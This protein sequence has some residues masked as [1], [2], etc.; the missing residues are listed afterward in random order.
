MSY[1]PDT[2]TI[3]VCN[4]STLAAGPGH[5][6]PVGELRARGS[7]WLPGGR[8]WHV[9]SINLECGLQYDYASTQAGVTAAR[10][11][12]EFV[13]K[14]TL[15][16]PGW[17]DGELLLDASG[18]AI[19]QRCI[20]I[21]GKATGTDP[22]N[23]TVDADAT[24]IADRFVL[25]FPLWR[26]NTYKP[27]DYLVPAVMM[28][29]GSLL[30]D[31]VSSPLTGLTLDDIDV[32]VTADLAAMTPRKPTP[33]RFVERTPTDDAAFDIV[34]KAEAW[35][36]MWLYLTG[37][38]AAAQ[39]ENEFQETVQVRMQAG[40]MIHDGRINIRSLLERRNARM[41]D[42]AIHESVTQPTFVP[43]VGYGRG[44]V[45]VTKLP[46][47]G[48]SGRV[49]ASGGNGNWEPASGNGTAALRLCIEEILSMQP[50]SVEEANFMRVQGAS[51]T[52]AF[53]TDTADKRVIKSP[54]VA[55]RLPAKIR[56]VGTAR[57]VGMGTRGRYG[58]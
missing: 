9:Q 40:H 10:R 36:A 7:E 13:Q 12:V 55:A 16:I 57:S 42:A 43:L 30:L 45:K 31:L 15:R 51:G 4:R 19:R 32:I 26:D 17:P 20:E 29:N 25:Q 18:R 41:F 52:Y 27:E 8:R 33:W 2:T 49:E 23:N 56:K 50:R 53:K 11:L 1:R 54:M 46:G 6:L 44:H 34:S 35:A 28:G 47:G 39:T 5:D 21:L 58:F 14:V 48:A 37:Q 24:D 38:L 22:S 3:Q